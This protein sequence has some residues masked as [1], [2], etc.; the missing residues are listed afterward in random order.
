V[1][2][3]LRRQLRR[4][5]G[6]EEPPAELKDL[7]AAI[8]SAY[9][10]SDSDREMV[11]RSLELASG[12][13]LERNASLKQDL[14]TRR[15]TEQQLTETLSV[16]ASTLDSTADGIL[17]ISTLPERR[18]SS[19]NQRFLDIWKVPREVL[20]TLN[21]QTLIDFV[22]PQI[23]DPD[24]FLAARADVYGDPETNSF[25][26]L[27]LKDGRI[28]ERTSL[29]Q[30]IDGKAV[31]R[32]WSFSDVSERAQ[33]ELA[34]QRSEEKFSKA[35]HRSPLGI[36]ITSVDDDRL[37]DVNDAFLRVTGYD[38]AEVIGKTSSELNV[39]ASKDF[40]REIGELLR[41]QG[42]ARDLQTQFLTKSGEVLDCLI[43]AELIELDGR[44]CVLSL[45]QDISD[46][47]RAELAIRASEEYFRT[48]IE[49]STDVILVMNRQ[50]EMTYVSPSMLSVMGYTPEEMRDLNALSFVHPDDLPEAM[51]TLE[52]TMADPNE[53]VQTEFRGRHADGSWRMLESVT[54]QI[55]GPDGQ[56]AVVMNFRDV[57]ERK[58][59]EEM[60]RFMAY[61]DALTSLPNRDLLRDRMDQ[62][63]V[64]ARRNDEHLAVIYLD[65]DRLK[66]VNDSVG[67]SGG[68]DLLRE[69]TE[70][71]LRISRDGDTLARVG[72]DE[73]V[74]LMPQVE[75][76]Q[77][78]VNFA[79]RV[80]DSLRRPVAVGGQEFRVTAS[81]GLAV[82]PDDGRDADTLIRNAD[83]AMYRA[84][85]QGRDNLQLY[86]ASMNAS[87]A[88]KLALER[89]LMHA[90]ERGEF[91][92]Y[93]QPIA[94]VATSRI[95]G[96]EALIRW[97]H[98]ERG[99]VPPDEFIPIAEETGLILQIGAWVLETAC[100]QGAE[101]ERMC[102][103]FSVAVNVSAKQLRE[104][105]FVALVR[106]A[107][108][109]SGISAG[110]LE[111]EVTE[112]AAM[113]SPERIAQ[114]LGALGSM[115]VR[116]VMD[117][118]GTG[119]SSLSHLK[120]LPLVK[121]KIDKSFTNDVTTD[122][123]D[124]AIASATIAMAHSLKLSV[125]AEGIETQEQLDFYREHGCDEFQGYFL[126]RPG[127]P[128]EITRMIE[129]LRPRPAA[130]TPAIVAP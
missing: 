99:L 108:W 26:V 128:E 103:G 120:Q 37:V 46:R 72:G 93:Y 35:F 118:F 77:E 39:W 97:R 47:V 110:A 75:K 82:F 17:V 13:L 94:D 80:L 96:A 76:I 111:L 11:E 107:L 125:T 36:V 24:T 58:R 64:Q 92:L 127:P 59:A 74:L 121:L 44:G 29:P 56:P 119:Y 51:K 22:L 3:L 69:V 33:A 49:K 18:I 5:L 30:R 32:V 40:R 27:T 23:V 2:S 8:D 45:V 62:A 60:I 48:L 67:H 34:L 20:E 87:V 79:N 126:A 104:P 117:D 65:L 21:P 71:L 100:R 89:E 115:G 105:N 122:P 124:A 88:A 55:A 73:F 41:E 19:F 7:L 57:S 95:V 14:E 43:T 114:A 106:D 109:N 4:F 50:A 90:Q 12:E 101:W 102:P 68:D 9:S 112:T 84:K 116:P 66:D 54:R 61:H 78:A 15:E 28:I 25:D 81:I 52:R 6:S 83:A 91:V 113:E 85:E 86:A 123:N 130:P 63:I 70:R 1:H 42:H 38:R 16:L 31:G 53:E 98:P 129:T 10:E